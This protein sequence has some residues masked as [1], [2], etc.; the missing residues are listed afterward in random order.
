MSYIVYILIYTHSS[1]DNKQLEW[2]N[3][4]KNT[5]NR[6][7]LPFPV[8]K[9]MQILGEAGTQNIFYLIFPDTSGYSIL[10]Y[11]QNKHLDQLSSIVGVVPYGALSRF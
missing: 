4:P 9:S 10:F 7:N 8:N 5:K 6:S 2:M 1:Y 3:W 11:H